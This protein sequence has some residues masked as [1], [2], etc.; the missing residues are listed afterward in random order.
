M[1]KY[2]RIPRE[3]LAQ[4]FNPPTGN[5]DPETDGDTIL[6]NKKHGWWI[7]QHHSFCPTTDEYRGTTH[8]LLH[9]SVIAGISPGYWIIVEGKKVT[10]LSD[11]KFKQ[12]FRIK[13]VGLMKKRK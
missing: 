7:T 10:C 9:A 13:P 12:E 6:E 4:Q 1:R 11:E 3:V 2:E 5:L 8:Q